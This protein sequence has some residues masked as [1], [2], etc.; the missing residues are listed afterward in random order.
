MADFTKGDVVRLPE[1]SCGPEATDF[2]ATHRTLCS[3]FA[4]TRAENEGSR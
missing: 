3:R 1:C 2:S 4:N